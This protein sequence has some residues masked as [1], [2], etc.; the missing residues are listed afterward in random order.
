MHLKHSNLTINIHAQNV[1]LFTQMY[2]TIII[3]YSKLD[4]NSFLKSNIDITIQQCEIQNLNSKKSYYYN[5]QN[6]TP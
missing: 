3:N 5:N 1:I 2:I 6:V 4:K